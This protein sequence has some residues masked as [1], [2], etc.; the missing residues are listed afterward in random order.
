MLTARPQ[1][2]ATD[3]KMFLDGIGLNLPIEN[4]TGLEDGSPQAKATWVISKTAEGYNDF[5]FC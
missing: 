2:A 1:I 4:I 5:L 3:I